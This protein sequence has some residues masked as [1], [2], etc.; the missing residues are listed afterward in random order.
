MRVLDILIPFAQTGRIGAVRIG[1]Q[2]KDVIVELGPPWAEGS[3][4]GAGGVP[5]LYAYGCLEVATCHARCQMIESIVVQTDWVTMEWPSRESGRAER[6]PGG[7]TYS[8]VLRAL[9]EA[10]CSWGVYEP[11]TLGDQ[12]A[13]RVPASGA[14]FVFT[15]E[16]V[17]EPVLCNVS[18]A[19]HRPHSCG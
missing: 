16:D 14:I 12:C 13:I 4:V 10:G 7:P 11:L 6:F 15:T 19:D 2:L 3:S 9:S 8:E 17:E 5:Y 1:A 18:V